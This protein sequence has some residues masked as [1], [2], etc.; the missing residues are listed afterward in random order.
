MFMSTYEGVSFDS[1]F[2]RGTGPPWKWYSNRCQT[3]QLQ[4]E[5]KIPHPQP[6]AWS[7]KWEEEIVFRC[8]LWKHIPNGIFPPR[9][10][11]VPNLLKWC[12]Q[13]EVD[14]SDFKPTCLHSESIHDD[15]LNTCVLG[16]NTYQR[17]SFMREN[18]FKD[19]I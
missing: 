17:N 11:H 3:W 10:Q 6:A 13:L 4:Q 15:A 18:L 9:G 14:F 2:Q 7:R 5:A 19:F 12:C 1:W 8:K 16:M